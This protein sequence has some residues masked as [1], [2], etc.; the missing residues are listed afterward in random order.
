MNMAAEVLFHPN[1]H[2]LETVLLRRQFHYKENAL[3]P[4]TDYTDEISLC[5]NVVYSQID[6]KLSTLVK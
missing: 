1:K 2:L 3:A 4:R 5:P 6:Q